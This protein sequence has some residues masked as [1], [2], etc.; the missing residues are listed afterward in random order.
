MY[1]GLDRRVFRRLIALAEVYGGPGDTV[2]IPLSQAQI[3]DLVGATRPS[4]NQ[5]LQRLVDQRLVELSRS[6]ISILDVPAL[7][8]R[9]R[10]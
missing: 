3:A 6:R 10:V 9:A 5:V 2:V 8:K 1:D 7:A 4:V